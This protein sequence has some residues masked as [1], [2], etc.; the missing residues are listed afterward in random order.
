MLYLAAAVWLLVDPLPR[1]A[2]GGN[3]K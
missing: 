3:A 2:A 1:P